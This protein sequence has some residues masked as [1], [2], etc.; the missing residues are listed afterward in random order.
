VRTQ[1]GSSLSG[2]SLLAAAVLAVSFA[3]PALAESNIPSNAYPGTTLTPDERSAISEEEA[4]TPNAGNKSSPP[5][6]T[7]GIIPDANGPLSPDTGPADAQPK[8]AETEAQ[9]IIEQ[10]KKNVPVTKSD[11]DRCISQWDPQTQMSKQEWAQ[12]CRTTL[13]YFP[14][15][16]N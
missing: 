3:L 4:V 13:Q 12:S 8:A 9:A 11:Y 7:V 5:P 6:G 10:S 15:K 16:S 14:E 2:S 1:F